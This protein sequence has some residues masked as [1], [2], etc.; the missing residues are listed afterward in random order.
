MSAFQPRSCIK[1]NAL[2]HAFYKLALRVS[3]FDDGQLGGR[4]TAIVS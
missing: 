3:P 4:N 2:D 1:V